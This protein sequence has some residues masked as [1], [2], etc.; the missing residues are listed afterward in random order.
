MCLISDW[1]TPVA[2]ASNVGFFSE[3]DSSRSE[4]SADDLAEAMLRMEAERDSRGA[5]FGGGRSH[6]SASV[7]SPS[8][9]SA[10]PLVAESGAGGSAWRGMLGG[11]EAA[12]P[13]LEMASTRFSAIFLSMRLS[14]I[15]RYRRAGDLRTSSE[16]RRQ[17]LLRIRLLLAS[18][19]V[20]SVADTSSECTSGLRD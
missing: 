17:P 18:E 1:R 12:T 9:S 7:C 10:E 4:L 11:K 15:S 14:E 13:A 3:H 20:G 6:S 19:M 16:I 2:N 8:V 5:S